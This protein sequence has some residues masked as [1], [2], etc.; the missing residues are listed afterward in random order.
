MGKRAKQ[1][2]GSVHEGIMS[3]DRDHQ[4]AFLLPQA[5]RAPD[6]SRSLLT[7]K[8]VFLAEDEQMLLWVIEEVLSG[9][10]CVVVGTATR[11]NEALAFVTTHTFDIAVFDRKLADGTIDPVVAVLIARGTPVI[12]ASGSTPS[13][14]AER[15]RNVVSIQKP[16]KDT[17]LRQALLRVIAQS[18]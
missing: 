7:G 4:A 6:A 3:T 1:N 8:R 2:G 10:G 12:I 5:E 15:F 13:E 11:V 18:G 17:D 14:F 9:F 16:Y